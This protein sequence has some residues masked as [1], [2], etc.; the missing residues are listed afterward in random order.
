[1]TGE[2]KS[3]GLLTPPFWFALGFGLLCVAA[4]LGLVLIASRTHSL[5]PAAHALGNRAHGR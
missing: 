4:G 3:M 5:G 2:R 1:M